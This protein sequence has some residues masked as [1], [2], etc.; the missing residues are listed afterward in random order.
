MGPLGIFLAFGYVAIKWAVLAQNIKQ[1]KLM[2]QMLEEIV[3]IC[4]YRQ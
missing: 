4:V 2:L 1:N 3:E